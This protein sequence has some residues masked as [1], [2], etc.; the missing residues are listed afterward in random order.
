MYNVLTLSENG[1]QNS[2]GLMDKVRHLLSSN[3]MNDLQRKNT[4]HRT[5]DRNS[6]MLDKFARQICAKNNI[7]AA[8][9]FW[10]NT[11]YIS[12]NQVSQ[13]ESDN[14]GAVLKQRVKDKLNPYSPSI[15]R[16]NT[17]DGDMKRL[18]ELKSSLSTYLN[19]EP[20]DDDNAYY[21]WW[22]IQHMEEYETTKKKL[23]KN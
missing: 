13:K 19:C 17:K 8:L 9:V 21:I 6:I 3:E 23:K 22:I 5:N 7:C 18:I 11:L 20:Y 10:N 16:S 1:A 4:Y 14:N 12:F 2:V 15:T